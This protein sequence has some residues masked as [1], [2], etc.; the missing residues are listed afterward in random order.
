[1]K[2]HIVHL[3][4]ITIGSLALVVT[5]GCDVDDQDLPGVETVLDPDD[6]ASD[7]ADVEEDEDEDE[8]EKPVALP[9]TLV[10]P[11]TAGSAGPAVAT[12]VFPPKT[13]IGDIALPDPEE[14]SPDP[15]LTAPDRFEVGPGELCDHELQNCVAGHL[16]KLVALPD[17]PDT[18]AP[19]CVPVSATGYWNNN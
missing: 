11:D 15:D 13:R 17:E 1:M 6:I 4:G 9:L 10:R 8:D 12:P 2:T 14:P 7:F 16:C 19:L 18:E 3:L 5:A